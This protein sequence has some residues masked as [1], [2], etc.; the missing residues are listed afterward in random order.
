MVFSR[1]GDLDLWMAVPMV[2]SL[3]LISVAAKVDVMVES[4][5]GKKAFG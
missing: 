1:V 2:V 4:K 5:V 3:G